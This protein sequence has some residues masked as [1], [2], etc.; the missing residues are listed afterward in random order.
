MNAFAISTKLNRRRW[1]AV[2]GLVTVTGLLLMAAS[3]SAPPRASAAEAPVDLG[4]AQTYAVL[5]GQ[6]ITNTGPSILFGDIGVSPGTA[7]TG[8]PPG[9]TLGVTHA[10]DTE[11]AA[12][13]SDLTTAYNDAASR[14]PT[15]NIA[16]DLGGLTL[17]PGVYKASSSI[18]LTDT[19][20]LDAQGNPA[21]VFI[22][23]IGSTLTTA[24]TSSINMINS[25][26]PCNVT[27]QIGSSATLG[28]N[29]DFTG[30]ILALTSITITTGT[31]VKGRALTR[32]GQVSLDTNTFTE[33]S[34]DTIPTTTTTTTDDTTTTTDDTTTTTTPPDD[35]TTTDETTTTTTP[36]DDTTTT[37]T[38][39]DDTTTT[40]DDT[41][42]TTEDTTT[43]TSETT[44]TTGDTTTSTDETSTTTDGTSTTTDDTT[45]TTDETSPTT[46]S[47]TST[48]SPVNT[49]TT[50]IIPI[51]YSPDTS[52]GPA[53]HND[54]PSTPDDLA[55]TGTNPWLPTLFGGGAL[56]LILGGLLTTIARGRKAS[57]AKPRTR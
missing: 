57:S 33:P 49:T 43:T 28:T 29:S 53:P 11:A 55:H 45:T 21:A 41:T 23:Q 52:G 7:I 30:T 37:T 3:L 5:G 18:G 20:T 15:A 44:T 14:A 42:T 19:L 8:F 51:T 9:T 27:W 16:D 24:S 46:D 47:S 31:T 32:N 1:T 22:F 54:Y 50:S 40:T 4:T 26:Q 25:A 48:T 13:Q 56:L 2:L 35:T 39:P 36:P 6:A 10:G 34:C 17:T 38:P 12:A